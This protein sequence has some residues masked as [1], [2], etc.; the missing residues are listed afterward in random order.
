MGFVVLSHSNPAR[1]AADIVT[2]R[3]AEARLFD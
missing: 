2:I 1:I 3:S